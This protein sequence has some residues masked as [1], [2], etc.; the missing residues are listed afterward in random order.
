VTLQELVYNI[1]YLS[2]MYGV[3]FYAQLHS[4]YLLGYS[5]FVFLKQLLSLVLLWLH[6]C[7][8]SPRLS[9]PNSNPVSSPNPKANLPENRES[10]QR[11]INLVP[12]LLPMPTH[13]WEPVEIRAHTRNMR[14]H[15]IHLTH[16]ASGTPLSLF[17]RLL[18]RSDRS[19]R[20]YER[21]RTCV[22]EI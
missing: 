8:P 22:T 14:A 6:R 19:E 17:S 1:F 3:L 9:C 5:P 20:V 15:T 7:S 4:M 11:L 13:V 12:K 16:S 2:N 18:H 10:G 21:G